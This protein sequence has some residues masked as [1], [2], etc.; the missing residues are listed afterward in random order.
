MNWDRIEGNWKQVKGSVKERWG[1]LTDDQLDVIAGKRDNLVGKI[2]ETYGI[3]KDETEK[4][5]VDWQ[6][7]MKNAM[8]VK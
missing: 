1:K 5:L 7:R 8:Q 4:Q 3:S 2:Q 6:K